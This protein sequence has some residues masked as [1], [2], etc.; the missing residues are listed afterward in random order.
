MGENVD[1]WR[2]IPEI[3]SQMCEILTCSF[4]QGYSR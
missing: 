1:S 2:L 3:V 4:P